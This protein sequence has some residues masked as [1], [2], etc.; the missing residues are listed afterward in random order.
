MHEINAPE[1]S[2]LILSRLN[3]GMSI[4]SILSRS[5]RGFEGVPVPGAAKREFGE[6]TKIDL[7]IM[8]LLCLP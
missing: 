6:V 4:A 8:H 5:P 1:V 7:A 2:S 3:L